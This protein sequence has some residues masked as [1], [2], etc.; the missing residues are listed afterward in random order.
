MSGMHTVQGKQVEIPKSTPQYLEIMPAKRDY[1]EFNNKQA[2]QRRGPTWRPLVQ[3]QTSAP[4]HLQHGGFPAGHL[5]RKE[6]CDSAIHTI[7]PFVKLHVRLEGFDQF[8]TFSAEEC[9][10]LIWPTQN[11]GILTPS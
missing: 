3:A 1:K 8:L 6:E 9:A 10:P 2:L 4:R 11:H 7:V 5:L